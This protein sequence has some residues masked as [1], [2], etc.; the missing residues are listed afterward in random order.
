M[1]CGAADG[2]VGVQEGGGRSERRG[3]S[4]WGAKTSLAFCRAFQSLHS[5]LRA[6]LE[7]R[8]V[9]RPCLGGDV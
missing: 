5:E 4:V 3:A 9:T 1:L 6:F 8:E 7:E 2:E